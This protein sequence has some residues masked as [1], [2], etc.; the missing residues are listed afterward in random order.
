MELASSD[1]DEPIELTTSD[2]D[3]LQLKAQGPSRTFNVGKEEEEKEAMVLMSSDE[4]A[5]IAVNRRAR[6]STAASST[7]ASPSTAASDRCVPSPSTAGVNRRARLMAGVPSHLAG[8]PKE[9]RTEKPAKGLA[10]TLAGGRDPLIRESRSPCSMVSAGGPVA[11]GDAGIQ[12][13]DFS[14]A[15]WPAEGRTEV[16]VDRLVQSTERGDGRLDA[17]S[18][19]NQT[20]VVKPFEGRTE[21]EFIRHVRSM[22][23]FMQPAE[24]RTETRDVGPSLLPHGGQRQTAS[25]AA[26]EGSMASSG[27]L[28]T[29]YLQPTEALNSIQ[30]TGPEGVARPSVGFMQ[31]TEGRAGTLD[32]S[33]SGEK[34]KA[35]NSAPVQGCMASAGG[36]RV[37]GDAASS[38]ELRRVEAGE[39]LLQ[40]TAVQP[41]LSLADAAFRGGADGGGGQSDA[42]L[43]LSESIECASAALLSALL[44]PPASSSQFTRICAWNKTGEELRLAAEAMACGTTGVPRL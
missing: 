4:D 35:N 40:P 39:A 42:A 24:A 22:T 30:P 10:E 11:D 15:S 3:E 16:E 27:G 25:S 26:V 18:V 9:G 7:A 14:P 43:S 19:V 21:V 12:D 17:A 34:R 8:K 2:D 1:E 31:P 6:L 37:D 38:L 5:P 20:S 13:G 41:A 33:A 32:H 44:F 36:S 29:D 28:T 23:G